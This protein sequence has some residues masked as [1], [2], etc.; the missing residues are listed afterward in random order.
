AAAST[1]A[2]AALPSSPSVGDDDPSRTVDYRAP[3][4][5][6]D[7][8]PQLGRYEIEG[9]IGHGGMGV[10]YRCRD[11]HLDR[12]L[13]LKGLQGRHKDDAELNHRSLDEARIMAGLQHPGIAPIH[14]VGCLDDGRPSSA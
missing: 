7:T 4:A 14:E 5:V 12:W 11:V 10:V 1:G 6:G 8:P 3:A 9:E 13:A 2:S